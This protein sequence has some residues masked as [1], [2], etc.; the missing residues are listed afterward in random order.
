MKELVDK[1]RSLEEEISQK[2]GEFSLFALFLREESQN[3]WDLV[4]SASWFWSDKKKTLDYLAKM[5]RSRLTSDELL[6]L[7]RIV[8]IEESDPM[9]QAFHQAFQVRHAPTEVLDCNLFGLQIKH[10][11]IITSRRNGRISNHSST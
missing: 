1:L 6:M 2:K 8:L 4:A 7:S 9:L 5:L 10:A 3:K 11:Y